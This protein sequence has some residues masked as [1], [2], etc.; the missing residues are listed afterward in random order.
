MKPAA[1]CLA[2][3]ASIALSAPVQAVPG[4]EI[5]TL[6]Q[7]RYTCEMPGDASGPVGRHVADADFTVISASS[8]RAHGTLGSYLLTGDQLVMTNGPHRGDRFVRQSR[9]FLRQVDRD[10][11]EGLLRCVLGRRPAGSGDACNGNSA[12]VDP[13]LRDPEAP[14]NPAPKQVSCAAKD[15]PASG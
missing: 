3:A 14:S 4:G 6:E 10:G 9:G 8:Y 5:G 11:N 15:R 7:G 1:Y 2:A 13:L 12:P